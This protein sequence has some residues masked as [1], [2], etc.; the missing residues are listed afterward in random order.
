M[1][2]DRQAK[3]SARISRNSFT[4]CVCVCV[5]SSQRQRQRGEIGCERKKSNMSHER[6]KEVSKGETCNKV[7]MDD[8]GIEAARLPPSH[9][10]LNVIL[11]RFI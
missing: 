2:K 1:F 6:E 8:G 5:C 7:Q 11:T 4:A 9:L 10:S 3:D